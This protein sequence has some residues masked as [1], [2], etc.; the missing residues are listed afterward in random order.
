MACEG[1]MMSSGCSVVG[2]FLW[3]RDTV[4]RAAARGHPLHL[5]LQE[6]DINGPYGKD[7][8][9]Q[10]G[11]K[12]D[13]WDCLLDCTGPLWS[14]STR[15]CQIG[16]PHPPHNPSFSLLA[17]GWYNRSVCLPNEFVFSFGE[18]WV[19]HTTVWRLHELAGVLKAE[20][21]HFLELC[22][23]NHQWQS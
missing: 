15:L 23:S 16:D 6:S 11:R 22:G 1:W 21:K 10:K 5:W 13:I 18:L 14:L 9:R 3:C 7:S 12:V 19:S 17:G 4:G 2:H 8:H 20:L